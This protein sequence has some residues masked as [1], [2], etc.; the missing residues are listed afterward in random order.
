MAKRGNGKTNSEKEKMKKLFFTFL[1]AI[2]LLSFGLSVYFT[3]IQDYIRTILFMVLGTLFLM[4]FIV[5]GILRVHMK[6]FYF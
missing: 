1:D 5:R 6:K 2:I 4:F 3:L